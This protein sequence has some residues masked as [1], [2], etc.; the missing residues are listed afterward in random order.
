[1]DA[2]AVRYGCMCFYQCDTN[3][4][5]QHCS[6]DPTIQFL[7]AL[8]FL[9]YRA[10]W[11]SHLSEVWHLPG[12][13]ETSS[14][15][16]L[17]KKL[18]LSSVPLTYIFYLSLVYCSDIWTG[19]GGLSPLRKWGTKYMVCH[20]LLFRAELCVQLRWVLKFWT[21]QSIS[22]EKAVCLPPPPPHTHIHLHTHF[23][24][25]ITVL[26]SPSV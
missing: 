9:L 22:Q 1:M 20:P 23:L 5:E 21:F 7:S 11:S 25:D 24:A 26:C 3:Y 19:G 16:S 14:S 13:T 6:T 18:Y 10:R 8:S 12:P 17:S 4:N 15:L 2:I